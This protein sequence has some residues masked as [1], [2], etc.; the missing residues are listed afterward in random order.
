MEQK[1]NVVIYTDG[2][3]YWKTKDGGFGIYLKYFIDGELKAEKRYFMGFKNTKVGRMELMGILF[4][5]K[6]IKRKDIQIDLYCDSQY[7]INCFNLK[8]LEKWEQLGYNNIKN[9]DLCKP[10][11][12]EKNKFSKLNFHWLKGHTNK[13]DINSIGNEIVD[14]LAHQGRLSAKLTDNEQYPSFIPNLNHLF[15]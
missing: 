10:L 15:K 9:E 14:K 3:C 11:L 7:A 4:A 1:Q 13:E 5:L 6:F 2:S 8:W 12:I